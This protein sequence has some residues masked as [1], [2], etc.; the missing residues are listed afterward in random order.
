MYRRCICLLEFSA[1]VT[2]GP[3]SCG[4][5]SYSEKSGGF[6]VGGGTVVKGES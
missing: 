1:R 5:D 4:S 6:S 3:K 2:V